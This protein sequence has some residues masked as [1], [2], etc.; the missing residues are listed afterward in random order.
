MIIENNYLT[1][2]YLFRRNNYKNLSLFSHYEHNAFLRWTSEFKTGTSINGD[3]EINNKR[4]F[5]TYNEPGYADYAL[6]LKF[7]SKIY[8]VLSDKS[9]LVLNF[10]YLKNLTEES[11]YMVDNEYIYFEEEIF[12]DMY[13]ADGLSAGLQFTQMI[14]DEIIIGAEIKY[15]SRNFTSLPAADPTGI[16]QEFLREDD[17]FMTGALINFDFA[18]ML[19]G[20]SLEVRWNYIRNKSNDYYFDYDNNLISFSINYFY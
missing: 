12:N 1:L 4:Y 8:Q 6:L 20:M 14:I 9:G 2:G 19:E 17:Q 13:S 11:R 15:L 18:F 7:S 16:S 3:A 10:E 5:D